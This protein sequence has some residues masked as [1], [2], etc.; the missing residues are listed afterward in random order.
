MSCIEPT[1]IYQLDEDIVIVG[2]WLT[3]AG[4]YV[5][6][7]TVFCK[8]KSPDDEIAT[9]E[10]GV[11]AA[12]IKVQDGWYKLAVNGNQEGTWFYRWYSTGDGKAAGEREFVVARS[13]FS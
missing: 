11:D 13:Q 7:D 2:E 1:N 5:D 10:Y 12:V 8:V 3:P 9:Y 4:E 6:P